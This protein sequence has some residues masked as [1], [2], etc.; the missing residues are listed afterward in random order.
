MMLHFLDLD[1]LIEE[2]QKQVLQMHK[3]LRLSVLCLTYQKLVETCIDSAS[4]SLLRS[5]PIQVDL[6]L[7]FGG[8]T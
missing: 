8:C 5:N 6:G 7:S 3:Y 1:E 4:A 2:I